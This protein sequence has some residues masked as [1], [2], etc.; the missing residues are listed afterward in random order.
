M[1]AYS[2]AVS[3]FSAVD[4][5]DDPERLVTYL[6]RHAAERPAMRRYIAQ[7]LLDLAG[8]GPV[9]DL[10][11]GGG[12]DLTLLDDVGLTGVGVDPSAVMVTAARSVVD[13]PLV[14]A[15]GESLPFTDHAFAGCW[16]ERVLMHV[17][18]PTAVLTEAVRCVEPGGALAIFEPDH[19]S[20]RLSTG[21]LPAGWQSPARHPS[22]AAEVGD[23]LADRGCTIHDRVEERSRWTYDAFERHLNV[24]IVLDRAVAAGTTTA[25]AVAGWLA[26]QR[27]HADAGTFR[28]EFVKV[29]WVTTTPA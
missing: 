13:A 5:A 21:P 18:D 28:A 19:S 20:L 11:C 2:S 12:H 16:I 7:T 15:T 8:T 27:G 9:L 25:A 4:E 10:G 23:L 17:D 24:R 22:I 29:L 6:D 1:Y 26:E 14:R 3:A